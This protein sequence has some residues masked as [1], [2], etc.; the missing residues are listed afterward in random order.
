MSELWTRYGKPHPMADEELA[1]PHGVRRWLLD[2]RLYEIQVLLKSL[3]FAVW[4]A[5]ILLLLIL[6]HTI[7][8][9]KPSSPTR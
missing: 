5:C 9:K 4:I 3:R 8:L 1:S 7:Q 6:L 2:C